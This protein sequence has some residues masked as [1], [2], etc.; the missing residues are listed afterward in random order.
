M[1]TPT[2]HT[3]STRA[4]SSTRRMGNLMPFS[5]AYDECGV[6]VYIRRVGNKG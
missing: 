1:S 6:K 2:S 3:A 5:A 4:F